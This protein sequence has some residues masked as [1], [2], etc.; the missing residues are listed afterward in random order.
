MSA[1]S[2]I[3]R[4]PAAEA[5]TL[6]RR[7][8]HLVGQAAADFRLIE[9][10]NRV[11]PRYS[12][13]KDGCMLLGALPQKFPILSCNLR[14]QGNLQHKAMQL[15]RVRWGRLQPGRSKTIFR[16]RAH[17]S[18]SQLAEHQLSA[19]DVAAVETAAWTAGAGA[20]AQA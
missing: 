5:N 16:A 19:P 18:P 1:H 12:G 2:A 15:M 14:A 13:G 9:G 6:A 20:A 11:P 17:V 4:T 3:S 8:C 7:Q 10:G